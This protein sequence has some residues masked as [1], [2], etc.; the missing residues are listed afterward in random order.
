[1][2]DEKDDK[3][4]IR[5][6]LENYDSVKSASGK[7]SRI[8]KGDPVAEGMIGF[9]LED[10]YKVADDLGVEI[11]KEKYAALNPGMQRMCIGNK[12][13]GWINKETAANEAKVAKKEK[14]G[15]DPMES[16]NKVCKPIRDHVAK[17]AKAKADEAAKKQAER[18]KAAKEKAKKEADVKKAQEKGKAA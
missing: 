3:V 4:V 13:R 18:E 9:P 1:M 8:R 6:N 15:P 7:K 10:V 5:P 17:E 2:A 11:P 16:F 12:I 14:A